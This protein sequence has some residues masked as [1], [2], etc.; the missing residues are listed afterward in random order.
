M[1]GSITQRAIRAL[2]A[3]AVHRAVLQDAVAR[4]PRKQRL[5]HLRA[6]EHAPAS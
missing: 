6:P 5:A 3:A 1:A 4:A 2:A